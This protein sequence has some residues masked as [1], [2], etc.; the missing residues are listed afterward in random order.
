L[1]KQLPQIKIVQTTDFISYSKKHHSYVFNELAGRV[2]RLYPHIEEVFFDMGDLSLKSLNQSVSLTLN[3]NIKHM[4]N[5]WPELL[6]Q[7]FSAKGFV[8]QAF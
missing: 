7:A 1:L 5:Q 2:R 3:A 4:D 8:A 6:W